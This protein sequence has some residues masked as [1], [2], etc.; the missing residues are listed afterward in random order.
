MNKRT[1][2][3]L[4]RIVGIGVF[5]ALAFVVSLTVR[6][7]VQF[8]TFDAKDAFICIASFIYGP[9][10]AVVISF[11]TAFLELVS[12]SSTGIWGFL[13]NFLSS[14]TFSFTASYIYSKHKTLNFAII[15]LYTA[16]VSTTCVMLLLN[17][18]VTPIYLGAPREAV[19]ALLP[20]LLLPFNCAKALLNGAI[21]MIIYKPISVSLRRA[22]LIDKPFSRGG[23]VASPSSPS[24]NAS[25][26]P[27][28]KER[29]TAEEVEAQEPMP[30][31]TAVKDADPTFIFN[32]SSV[33][34]L[35][36]GAL[37]VAVAVIIFLVIS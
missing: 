25:Q 35:I 15:G 22:R 8:L 31:P 32:R 13:M 23:V 1:N 21:V 37:T 36:F 5:A 2:S 16:V 7:P 12:V 33:I 19:I 9:I 29:V 34:T 6:I 24:F 4:K 30:V 3:E 27:V 20:T 11:I 18:F 10:A 28:D 17:V 14:A 26:A